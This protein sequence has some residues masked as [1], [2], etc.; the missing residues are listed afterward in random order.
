MWPGDQQVRGAQLRDAAKRLPPAAAI[1]LFKHFLRTFPSAQPFWALTMLS[2]LYRAGPP[3]DRDG[4]AVMLRGLDAMEY[5]ENGKFYGKIQVVLM[6]AYRVIGSSDATLRALA[7][8]R[9]REALTHIDRMLFSKGIKT[10]KNHLFYSL[11]T[12]LW[13]LLIADRRLDDALEVMENVAANAAVRRSETFFFQANYNM[14]RCC[15][16]LGYIRVLQQRWSE[17]KAAIEVAFD[18]FQAAGRVIQLH[19]VML[20]EFGRTLQLVQATCRLQPQIERALEGNSIRRKPD[21]EVDAMFIEHGFRQDNEKLF[22]ILVELLE[23]EAL[24]S[25]GTIAANE[26]EADAEVS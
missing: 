21:R 26:P 7:I 9:T 10:D 12:A 6:F 11:H 4:A 20:G 3:L 1:R 13:H 14:I 15:I 24:K 18:L 16:M 5:V 17:A 2:D 19:H 8:D 25:G 22:L 23:E